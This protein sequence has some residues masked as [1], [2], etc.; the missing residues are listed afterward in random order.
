MSNFW[1]VM[2]ITAAICAAIH[3][4]FG[5]AAPQKPFFGATVE[6]EYLVHNEEV[7]CVFLESDW[8]HKDINCWCKAKPV[9]RLNHLIIP[10]IRAEDVM[11]KH[12]LVE[13]SED[14][15]L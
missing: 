8:S 1:R 7:T 9:H 2:F 4:F 12:S 3:L 10:F 13:Q 15:S 5:C 11:C 6:S 14:P